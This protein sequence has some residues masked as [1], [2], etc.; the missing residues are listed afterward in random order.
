MLYTCPLFRGQEGIWCV[1]MHILWWRRVC[2][3]HASYTL[4]AFFSLSSL[5]FLS[6]PPLTTNCRF[7]ESPA[8]KNTGWC[9]M[10]SP[11]TT[12]SGCHLGKVPGC[13]K[14]GL[15][16]EF[17]TDLWTLKKKSPH[18]AAYTICIFSLSVFPFPSPPFLL[19]FP[20]FLSSF[21]P[22]LL[23]FFSLSSLLFPSFPLLSSE[24]NIIF[25]V[26]SL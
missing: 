18:A 9:P 26:L 21:P 22:F 2:V 16:P 17:L 23:F 4:S 24:E 14:L 20:L 7:S 25:S 1:S 19:S 3:R 5:L 8:I 15:T 12:N 6:F 11:T 13:Q 10:K